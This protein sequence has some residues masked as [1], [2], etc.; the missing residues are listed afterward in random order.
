M[1]EPILFRSWRADGPEILAALRT[2]YAYT[3][4][5]PDR[6]TGWLWSARQIAQLPPAPWPA[7]LAELGPRLLAQLE[8]DTGTVF[9][10]ACFQAYLDGTGCGWHYDRDWDEQAVLSLGITRKFGLRS[11]SGEQFLELSDGD[12][13][14]MPPGFQYEWEHCVPVEDV[15]G[16]RCSIVFRAV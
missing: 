10:A 6:A 5:E 13:I 15:T 1:A 9:E 11:D 16:E 3:E 8:E 14:F 12:M 2:Q 7:E 4:R